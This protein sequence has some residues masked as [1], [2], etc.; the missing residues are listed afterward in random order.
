M[1]TTNYFNTFISVAEDSKISKSE[2]P[3][4]REGK[5]SI[6]IH[7]YEML[8]QKP[9]EFNSDDVLFNIYTS[10]N[11]IPLS[12][13][14]NER[15]A[16]FNKGQACLRSS[17]LAKRYG[18]G[19]HHNADGKVAIVAKNSAEYKKLAANKELTQ[20]TALANKRI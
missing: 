5:K 10:R 13:M 7:Q 9:Y 17:T 1:K 12:Q 19:I 14:E 3:L 11:S 15:L 18:W 20:L 8:S 2:V 4:E 6:A 16:F